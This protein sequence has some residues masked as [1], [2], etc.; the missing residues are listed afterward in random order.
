ML[1]NRLIR[2]TGCGECSGYCY[3]NGYGIGWYN[4]MLIDYMVCAVLLFLI[5]GV[6]IISYHKIKTKFI[7]GK[8]KK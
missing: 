4:Y 5:T 3:I 7:K 8:Y 6:L 1:I 2:N